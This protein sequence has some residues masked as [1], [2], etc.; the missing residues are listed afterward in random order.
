MA[1]LK[2]KKSALKRIGKLTK[3]GK[4]MRLRLSSQHL[5]SHKSKRTRQRAKEKTEFHKSNLKRLKKLVPGI[6]KHG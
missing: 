5:A 3:K 2:T 6:R 4:V 1:K